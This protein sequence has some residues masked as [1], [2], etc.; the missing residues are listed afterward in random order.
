MSEET[1]DHL[2]PVLREALSNVVKHA[3]A[4]SVRIAIHLADDVTLV[5]ADDGRGPA[6]PTAG[7]RGLG[8]MADR[9]LELGG[10]CTVTPREAGG[11]RIV[12]VAVIMSP[13]YRSRVS[14]CQKHT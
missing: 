1:A 4:E 6:D 2:V 8:N 10:E 5:V 7:G 12:V 3:G 11:T 14:G 13:Q 9:A